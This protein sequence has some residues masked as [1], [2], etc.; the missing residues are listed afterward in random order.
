ML[1][2]DW[3]L[4]CDVTPQ[5]PQS[6]LLLLYSLGAPQH[7]LKQIN[8]EYEGSERAASSNSRIVLLVP[9]ISSS[10]VLTEKINLKK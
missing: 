8:A 7:C 2:A 9:I 1:L 5:G 10:E 4:D 3:V 6:C